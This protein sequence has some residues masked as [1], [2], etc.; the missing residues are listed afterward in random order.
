MGEGPDG[1]PS[2]LGRLLPGYEDRPGQLAMAEAIEAALSFD[3]PLFVEAGTGTGKTLA[4]LIPAVLS[5]KRVVVSTA[6][7]ALQE[8]IVDKDLPLVAR[9]LA[10]HGVVFRAAMMKGLTNYLCKRRLDEA[11][12]S[13]EPVTPDLLR[14]ERWARETESGD[15]GEIEDLHDDADAWRKVQ[16][17]TETRIGAPCTHYE[18]CFVTRMRRQAEEA[19]I[20]VVNHHLF[21]ADLAL[22]HGR[23]D[24]MRASALPPYDAVIFDE[25]HQLEDVATMFF[26]VSASSARIEALTRDARRSFLAARIPDPVMGAGGGRA[27]LDLVDEAAREFFA[28]LARVAPTARGERRALTHADLGGE[29]ARAHAR[30]AS[31]LDALCGFAESHLADEAVALVGRRTRELTRDLDRIALDASNEAPVPSSRG[32]RTSV[33]PPS[34]RDVDAS[35][36]DDVAHAEEDPPAPP[37]ELPAR[38][39]WL[40]VRERSVV[41]GASLVDVGPTLREALF[42]RVPG[43]VCTSATLATAGA[44]HLP[45]LHFAK[46]RLGA[47]PDAEELVVPSPFDFAS[48]A[49]LYV[50]RDLPEPQDAD[51]ARAVAERAAELVAITGGGAFLLCTSTR[52]MR[53]AHAELAR[54]LKVPLLLQGDA[55]KPRLLERFRAAGDAVLVAT[56]GFWE[57]VDVPGRALRLVI[58]DKIP[59][60]VPTDPVVAARGAAI[61]RG[62]GNPFSQYSVPSA[63][64]TLKQGFGRL[65]RTQ[66]D[67]GIVALLDRRAKTRGYGRA[68]LAGLPPARQMT[69]LD[70]VRGFWAA[71]DGAS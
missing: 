69:S 54:R 7:R 15:R 23:G 40:E 4:Y 46:A 45:S 5:G 71:I 6:T 9:L 66:K 35:F 27:L 57:G 64:L 55:P 29:T 17:S 33:P 42:E 47:P 11:R 65:I 31:S 52:A 19:Q 30:L 60:A 38:V 59:F 58:L 20:V 39:A 32:R 49:A 50:P 51:F 70:E 10:E 8:Q 43:V 22:R 28:A 63:A 48:R 21:C 36:F 2:T 16:S 25:A 18:S 61:E 14:I 68:L 67:A 41:L 34:G 56:M 1:S 53:A 44:Q 13:G 12:T 37:P 3:R 24:G 26:G 62:G